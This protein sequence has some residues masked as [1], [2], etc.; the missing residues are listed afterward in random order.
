MISETL[1]QCKLK[2]KDQNQT[3]WIPTKFAVEGRRVGL[4]EKTPQGGAYWDE[5]WIV[6]SVFNTLPQDYVLER[7]KDYKETRRASDI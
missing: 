4:R 1:T 6:E 7:S 5:G 2:R 3:L